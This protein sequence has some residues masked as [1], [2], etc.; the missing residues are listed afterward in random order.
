VDA[1]AEYEELSHLLADVRRES[2]LEHAT[3]AG[4]RLA[5]AAPNR[6]L[7]LPACRGGP[8]PTLAKG[9]TV[10]M[11][12]S[13]HTATAEAIRLAETYSAHNYAPLPVVLAEAD[14]CWVADVEGNRYLDLL[15]SYS[16]LNFG[17]RHPRLLAAAHA[18]LD[19]MTLTSRAFHTDLLGPMCRDLAA[20]V[21]QEA[22]LP[23]N[24]GAEA[25]ETAIKLVRRWGYHRK[26]VDRDRAR[27]LV[28]DNNFHGRTTTLVGF[29]SN[30][31]ARHGFGPFA[32]GFT[33]IP[34]G[35]ADALRDAL[36]EDVVGF[37]VEP[38]QG[39]GG[40]IVPPRG[41]LAQAQR[42]CRDAGA[43]L[44]ADEIQ[45][46]LGRTGA[47]L[48]CDHEAVTPD[49]L[50]LGKALGGGIVPASAVLAS[51]EIMN[52]LTPGSHGSTFGGNPL[53]CA[54]AREVVALLGDG[55][56][57]RRA[58][59]LSSRLLDGLRAIGGNVAAVRGRGLW[60]GVDLSPTAQPAKHVCQTL[61]AEGLLTKDTHETTLRLAP[62]LTIDEADL[63]WAVQRL[64]AVLG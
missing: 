4:A 47:T 35:D 5:D 30:D 60:A 46:G 59:A 18:Q 42:L 56:L 17:H 10:P 49:V 43:L 34:F 55:R 45:S 48:A 39:E 63:D 31:E 11:S 64:A 21:G 7:A 61:L 8:H 25:V 3:F 32:P 44:V 13:A 19:R 28:C 36:D 24:S 20:L 58:A 62:P 15:A 29:S 54:I 57:Q 27:I 22:V 41:Y 26:G 16:A 51:H 23:M 14:G 12:A 6:P 33:S 2:D 38:I 52:V 1:S 50:I 37:L 53:M 40:V 9:A